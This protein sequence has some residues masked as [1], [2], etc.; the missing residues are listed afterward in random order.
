MS[1]GAMPGST[2]SRRP[3]APSDR[4]H[5]LRLGGDRRELDHARRR[6]RR[7]RRGRPTASRASRVLPAPPGPSSVTSR[8]RCSSSSICAELALAADEARHRRGQVRAP[9]GRGLGLQHGQ[10]RLLELGRGRH[11]EL[12]V[13]SHGACVR[14]RR[15]RRPG[16]PR[17]TARRSAAPRAARAAGARRAALRARATSPVSISAATRWSSSRRGRL[18]GEAVLAQVGERRAAPQLE[19]G[20]RAPVGQRALELLHVGLRP[21]SR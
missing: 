11:A 3:S 13:E 7:R 5:D 16:G 18:L 10:V 9:R 6:R 12:V 15:A 19:R 4:G 20:P 17:R 8:E 21:S 14:R 2:A 1:R